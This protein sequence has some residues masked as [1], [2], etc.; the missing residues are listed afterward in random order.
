MGSTG[1]CERMIAM[2]RRRLMSGVKKKWTIEVQDTTK[3]GY[4]ASAIYPLIN[5]AKRGPGVYEVNDGDTITLYAKGNA[6]YEVSAVIRVNGTTVATAKE[7]KITSYDYTVNSSCK[8]EVLYVSSGA[9]IYSKT[10]NTY[11][12]T[13]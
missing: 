8:I 1:G 11:L 12:T 2:L 3:V 10:Q 6:Y 7:S 13:K 5:G 9:A 4:T